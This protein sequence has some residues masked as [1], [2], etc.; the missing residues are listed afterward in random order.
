M[1]IS[2]VLEQEIVRRILAVAKPDRVIVFGSAAAGRMT[3]D[4]DIDL[5]VVEP[6]P[7]KH[8]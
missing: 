3:A 7:R 6:V 1:G 5:L 2:A 8:P 4:S